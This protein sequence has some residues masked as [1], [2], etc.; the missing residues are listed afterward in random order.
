[1]RFDAIRGYRACRQ[2][3]L[4]AGWARRSSPSSALPIRNAQPRRERGETGALADPQRSPAGIL[5][6]TCAARWRPTAS[7][8]LA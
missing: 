1:V 4:A 3:N 5:R 8:W 2:G 7:S 6:T